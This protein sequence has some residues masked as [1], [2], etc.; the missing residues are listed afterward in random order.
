MEEKLDEQSESYE[1]MLKNKEEE[2]V[3]LM[4]EIEQVSD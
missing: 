1:Y 4:M 2:K 3:N